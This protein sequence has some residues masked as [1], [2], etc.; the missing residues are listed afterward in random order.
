MARPCSPLL[1]AA[2]VASAP[3]ARASMAWHCSSP[4]ASVDGRLFWHGMAGRRFFW[5]QASESPVLRGRPACSCTL[6]RS[7]LGSVS[8]SLGPSCARCPTSLC[9]GPLGCRDG[10]RAG[11]P[12]RQNRAACLLFR[13]QHCWRR[14]CCACGCVERRLNAGTHACVASIRCARWAA[15]SREITG[16][17]CALQDKLCNG[18]NSG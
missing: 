13:P 6:A 17:A 16:D 14:L 15:R 9:R 8:V 10:R 3:L 4:P 1:A 11:L 7:G 12:L 18:F 5:I 2:L